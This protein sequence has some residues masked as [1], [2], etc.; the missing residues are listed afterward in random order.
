VYILILRI[1]QGVDVHQIYSP[2]N[3]REVVD[4]SK[5]EQMIFIS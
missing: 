4:V 1:L 5:K 2:C 3:I